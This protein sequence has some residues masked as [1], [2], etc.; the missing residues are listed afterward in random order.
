MNPFGKSQFRQKNS[1]VVAR[2]FRKTQKALIAYRKTLI[3][4]ERRRTAAVGL[5]HVTE[6]QAD[7][8]I[9]QTTNPGAFFGEEWRP[10]GHCNW[11]YGV[12]KRAILKLGLAT[13]LEQFPIDDL[14]PALTP[15]YLDHLADDYY[16]NSLKWAFQAG[17]E[18]WLEWMLGSAGS[19]VLVGVMSKSWKLPLALLAVF[20]FANESFAPLV[21]QFD[22]WTIPWQQGMCGMSFGGSAIQVGLFLQCLVSLKRLY[23]KGSRGWADVLLTITASMI[24]IPS[25]YTLATFPIDDPP[26]MGKLQTRNILT[27]FDADGLSHTGHTYGI[28]LGA[29]TFILAPR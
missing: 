20:V 27:Y 28:L 2:Y 21:N 10:F 4:S 29:L 14:Q 1:V 18:H 7:D 6:K 25:M 8:L 9:D 12:S 19:I 13:G 3:R 11:K 22:E 16:N 5:F 17:N 15:E 23:S 24:G 26:V